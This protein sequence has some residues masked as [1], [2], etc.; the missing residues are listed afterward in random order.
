MA[1]T[2]PLGI[3]SA[4]TS[5]SKTPGCSQP[6]AL[7][8]HKFT[9]L[10]KKALRFGCSASDAITSRVSV[11][12]TAGLALSHASGV[13]G[14][15]SPLGEYSAKYSEVV[16]FSSIARKPCSRHFCISRELSSPAVEV[17]NN[18]GLLRVRIVGNKPT[19]T[20]SGETAQSSSMQT[21][22]AVKP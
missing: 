5:L 8:V 10:L 16:F 20:L 17:I 14:S 2:P 3:G 4:V 19:L 9:L 18:S 1:S 22:S 12:P 15:I 6:L 11:L 13:K 7:A 21:R